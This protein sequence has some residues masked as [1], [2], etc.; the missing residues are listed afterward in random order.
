[1]RIEKSF[2]L[3][4]PGRTLGIYVDLLNLTNQGVPFALTIVEQSG[5]TY[6]EPNT[7]ADPRSV[8]IAGRLRF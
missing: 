6:G 2:P 1:M 5:A 7:W 8:R 3:G 4:R